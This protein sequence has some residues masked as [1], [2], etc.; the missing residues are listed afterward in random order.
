MT[1]GFA[2]W[3]AVTNKSCFV[4]DWYRW[5]APPESFV[6]SGFGLES[7][8]KQS[9]SF[10]RIWVDTD[11]FCVSLTVEWTFLEDEGTQTKERT[12]GIGV[13]ADGTEDAHHS[14]IRICCLFVFIE[15]SYLD[16][17]Q[18]WATRYMQSRWCRSLVTSKGILDTVWLPRL[19]SIPRSTAPS[20]PRS[21]QTYQCLA[22]LCIYRRSAS[23]TTA[24]HIP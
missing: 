4:I 2:W 17:M 24:R 16:Q 12:T 20:Q 15:Q 8:G 11:F 5:N 3:I 14:V 18:C 23:S 10:H 21:W 22:L 13:D 6:D 7:H 9:L 1:Q 19:D